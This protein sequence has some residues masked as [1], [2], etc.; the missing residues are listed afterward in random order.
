MKIVITM[1]LILCVI[2]GLAF[3]QKKPDIAVYVTD[4]K[5]AEGKFKQPVP[6]QENRELS[7]IIIHALVSSG[8]YAGME[9]NRV[10]T[11]VVTQ[12]LVKKAGGNIDNEIILKKAKSAGAKFVFIGKISEESNSLSAYILDVKSGKKETSGMASG[13]VKNKEGRI[14]LA[15]QVVDNMFPLGIQFSSA[16]DTFTDSRDGKRYHIKRIGSQ[17]WFLQDL[18]NGSGSYTWETAHSACPDGWSLPSNKDWNTLKANANSSD[19]Q[20]FSKISKGNWWSG[21]ETREDVNL[22][23]LDGY[24]SFWLVAGGALGLLDRAKSNRSPVRCFKNN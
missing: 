7:W 5:T 10:F 9:G 3:A 2:C 6:T 4:G 17:T 14:E 23:I 12:D 15:Y 24:A 18:N 20:D 11:E 16:T 19:I 8:Q 22:T 1:I 13:S 21:T